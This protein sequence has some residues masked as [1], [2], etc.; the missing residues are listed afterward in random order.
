MQCVMATLCDSSTIG[1]CMVYGCM[2]EVCK[3]GTLSQVEY[4]A[5]HDGFQQTQHM[6]GYELVD[7]GMGRGCYELVHG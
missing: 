6:M 3:F 5:W 7:M 2:R 1:Q 4:R